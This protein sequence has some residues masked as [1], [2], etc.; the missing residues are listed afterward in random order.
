MEVVWKVREILRKNLVWRLP[1]ESMES[2]TLNRDFEV[3]LVWSL[4]GALIYYVFSSETSQ[5]LH[6]FYIYYGDNIIFP[7]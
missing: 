3:K 4:S 1:R 6:N 2:D 7:M 5:K